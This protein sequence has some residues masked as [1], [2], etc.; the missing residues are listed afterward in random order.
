MRFRQIEAFRATMA[1]GSITKAAQLLCIGQP[2]VSRL[3]ADLETDVGFPLFQRT[4]GR[5]T[6]TTEALR[7]HAA[8]ERAFVSMDGLE[9]LADQIRSAYT[10]H[11]TVSTLPVWSSTVM[12]PVIKAFLARNPGISLDIHTLKMTEIMED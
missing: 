4:A 7:F 3:I 10:G 11:L 9:R 5:V 1:T 12:P 2:A 6:P 8:V